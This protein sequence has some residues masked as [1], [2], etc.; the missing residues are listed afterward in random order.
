M[1]AYDLAGLIDVFKVKRTELI[2]NAKAIVSA[3]LSAPERDAG[4][5]T[6]LPDNADELEPAEWWQHY[7][8]ASR[9]PKDTESLVVRAG[10][11]IAAIASRALAA[12]KVFGQLNDGDVAI[13][14]VAGNVIR[15]NASGSISVLVPT[16]N[17]KQL[18]VQLSP[19]GAGSIKAM[20]GNGFSFELSDENGLAV[21]VGSKPITFAC[22]TFQVV[23]KQTNLYTASTKLSATAITPFPGINAAGSASGTVAPPNPGLMV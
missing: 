10:A 15:L 8:F 3:V 2:G 23:G 19:K 22:G 17:G 7:G 20:T 9:P 18:I 13:Y 14:S 11:T 4:D 6:V 21:N 1:S 12:V 16:A 5:D